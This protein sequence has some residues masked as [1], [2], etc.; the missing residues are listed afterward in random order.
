MRSTL[1]LTLVQARV[2]CDTENVDAEV[3]AE[4]RL[5]REQMAALVQEL[6]NRR[7]SAAKRTKTIRGKRNAAAPLAEARHTA[8]DAAAVRRALR[9]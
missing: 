1:C 4:L 2:I 3:L 7:R 5:L 6:R 8:A 9:R